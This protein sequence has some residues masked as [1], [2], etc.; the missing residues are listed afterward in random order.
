MIIN[1]FGED[2]SDKINLDEILVCINIEFGR[3]L[4]FQNG[5]G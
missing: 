1:E 3:I 4:W 2:D 5:D